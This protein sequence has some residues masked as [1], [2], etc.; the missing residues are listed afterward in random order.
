MIVSTARVH[1]IVMPPGKKDKRRKRGNLK[2]AVKSSIE[3]LNSRAAVSSAERI[4]IETTEI[5]LVMRLE[6]EGEGGKSTSL[7]TE[8]L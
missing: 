6:V 8:D 1:S 7:I 2:Q 4:N 5:K 3:W